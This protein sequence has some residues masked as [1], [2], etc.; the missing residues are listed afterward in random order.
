M[1]QHS[2]SGLL[3]L[4]FFLF[5]GG[6]ENSQDKYYR[7]IL[8]FTEC[9]RIHLQ[10]LMNSLTLLHKEDFYL[11]FNF[12]AINEFLRILIELYYILA[13]KLV[14]KGRYLRIILQVLSSDQNHLLLTFN[15]LP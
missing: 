14:S 6:E 5:K 3:L 2:N 13:H 9:Q 1:D 15:H 11:L 10:L 7:Q 12:L 4:L 8:I